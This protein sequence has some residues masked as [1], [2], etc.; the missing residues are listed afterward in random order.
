MNVV[1][2][3]AKLQKR[4]LAHI[5]SIAVSSSSSSASPSLNPFSQNAE[6]NLLQHRVSIQAQIILDHSIRNL[7]WHLS[8]RHLMLRQIL[9]R[10]STAIDRRGELIFVGGIGDCQFLE[11]FNEGLGD[12]PVVG[13]GS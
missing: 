4:Q 6:I 7:L 13:D 2:N 3:E 8:F 5:L 10:E 1:T 12:L 9:S 11:A